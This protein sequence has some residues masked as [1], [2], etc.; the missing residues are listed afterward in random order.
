MQHRSLQFGA[1]PTNNLHNLTPRHVVTYGS[2]GRLEED[3]H[4]N[5]RKTV[6]P[7][8]ASSNTPTAPVASSSVEDAVKR[9]GKCS[10]ATAPTVCAISRCFLSGNSGLTHMVLEVRWRPARQLLRPCSS[11]P[12]RR[13]VATDRDLPAEDLPQR[14]PELL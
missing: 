10:A 3:L 13:D 12:H 14:G 5:G 4:D 6:A 1:V 7:A 2:V 8:S 9:S 11:R